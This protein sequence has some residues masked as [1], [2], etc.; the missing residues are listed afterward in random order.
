VIAGD[1]RVDAYRVLG[2]DD[3]PRLG[4]VHRGRSAAGQ[5]ND[6]EDESAEE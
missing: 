5:A 2:A 6:T 1:L 4:H 3:A